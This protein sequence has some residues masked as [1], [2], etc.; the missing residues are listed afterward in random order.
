MRDAVM[1]KH[2]ARRVL[3]ANANAF[4]SLVADLKEAMF[5]GELAD[6]PQ[7][8]RTD[9]GKWLRYRF[10]LCLELELRPIIEWPAC[11]SRWREAH[12]VKLLHI[13]RDGG[14]LI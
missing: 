2:F 5:L 9:S 14:V 4:L 13:L 1:D 3:G 8:L 7:V 11:D 12:R 6:E 10:A